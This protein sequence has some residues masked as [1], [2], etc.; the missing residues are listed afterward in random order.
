MKCT[1]MSIGDLKMKYRYGQINLDP[2]YQR[3][4]A[5]KTRQRLL[6]LSSLFNGIPIPALI[7][8]KYFDSRKRKEVFDVL[9]GKQRIETILHFIRLKKLKEEKELWV[10]FIN[11]QT[12]KYDHLTYNELSSKKVNK[13]YENLLEKFW[14]YEIPIIEYEE[15]PI[16]FFGRN[17]AAKEIFVRINSTG[18]PLRKHE[19]RHAKN[20]GPFFQLGN[21]LERRFT[22]QFLNWKL[23]NKYEIQRYLLHEFILELCT[24]I[25]VGNYSDRRKKLEEML[26]EPAWKKRELSDIKSKFNKILTWIKNIFPNDTIKVTRFK[27][28]SDFYSLFAVLLKM[29]NNKYVTV[30][31]RTNRIAGKFLLSF[32]RQIQNI[33]LRIRP[34]SEIKMSKIE[35]KLREYVVSTRQAT[36][37]FKNREIRDQYLTNVLKDGFFLKRKD[38]KRNFDPIVKDLLWSEL[39]QKDKKP[40]CPNPEK[41]GKCFRILTYSNAQVDHKF[42]WSKGGK[43][44]LENARLLCSSC[45]IRKGNK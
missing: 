29:L 36:D 9:D 24:V 20:S 16:D 42:P 25:R 5:W 26:G 22:G 15:D 7:F 44:N 8:H 13:I 34:Y 21:E 40:K 28:R 32:S 6:L 45:N 39:I 35:E 1:S 17:V 18:S 14:Q 2:P 12:N 37:N 23:T 4:P 3:K 30:D 38:L 41:N 31:R 10:E 27:N 43:T 19:I 33:D 11:P